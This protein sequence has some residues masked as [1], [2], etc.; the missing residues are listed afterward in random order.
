VKYSYFPGCSLEHNAAAYHHS[1]MAIAAPLGIE[2]AEIE[3]WNCCGATEYISLNMMASFAL[4]ARNLAQATRTDG[5]RPL[6]APC[7]ACYLNLSKCDHYMHADPDLAARVNT[8]LAAGGLHYD[9][10]TVHVRHLLDVISADVGCERLREHVT[11]PLSGLKIAPYYGCLIS[12]PGLRVAEHDPEYPTSLDELLTCLGA[13]V[14]DF[15]LKTHC[16]GGHMTQI[17]EATGFELIRRLVKGAVDS[18]ADLIVTICPMCQLNLDA[19]QG[20]MN[21]Y[22][23]TDYKMPVLY[24]TQMMGLAFGM[25]AAHLDIGAEL[26]D[27]RP[28]LAKIGVELPPPPPEAAPRRRRD[29]KSLPMPDMKDVRKTE[30]QGAQPAVAG[31]EGER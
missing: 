1:T 29:D 14:V 11:R 26:V 7:S 24:F 20:A 4:I 15:P 30:G 13:Q 21:R 28:A 23:K 5:Q 9:P 18:G 16:C 27:A 22:F 17:S 6:V 3:D 31:R 10:G 12:R 25:D 2:F 8:A 19:F